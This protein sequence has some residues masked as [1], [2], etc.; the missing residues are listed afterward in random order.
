MRNPFSKFLKHYFNY[1]K[2]DR[3]AIIV[4]V[5]LII[6][7]IIVNE[8]IKHM[9]D[10]SKYDYSKFAK[11]MEE[12]EKKQNSHNNN[13]KRLFTF[14]PNTI[15]EEKLDSLLMPEFV[16]RNLISYRNA[17]GKFSESSDLNKLYGM[18]DSIFKEIEK[19]VTIPLE[20]NIQQQNEPLKII[21]NK[22][23]PEGIFDPNT[24]DKKTL[25]YFG[26][27]N[28]QA[29]NLL[30]YRETGGEFRQTSDL[31][32]IYGIDSSFLNMINKYVLIEEIK[33]SE[34]VKRENAVIVELNSAD[35]SQLLQLRGIGPAFASRI[36]KYRDL[37]GGFYN[38][39]QLLEVYNFPIETYD[40]ISKNI[41][42]DTLKIKQIRINFAKYNEL[43]KHPYLDAGQVN[44]ILTFREKNGSF[45]D[46]SQL[47]NIPGI[48]STI[49]RRIFPYFTCR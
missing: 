37:L 5:I 48:D 1:S 33:S 11:E 47:I 12:L 31:L 15:S 20:E 29:E 23:E 30:R 28:F 45:N 7:G 27:N 39:A 38:K 17:G 32:I 14:N 44:S 46:V 34:I 3:N 42:V 18:N 41:H 49:Y 8:I 26:L 6:S 25:L 10:N 22:I 43:S 40:N 16:K 36:L 4:I 35:S 2:S 21:D 24:A 9:P 13:Y 19:Y